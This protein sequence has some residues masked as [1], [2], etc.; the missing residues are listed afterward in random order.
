[1]NAALGAVVALVWA[2]AVVWVGSLVQWDGHFAV[3]LVVGMTLEPAVT[4]ALVLRR[5]I[6]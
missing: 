5:R 3:G 1:M 6:P 2:V 4:L